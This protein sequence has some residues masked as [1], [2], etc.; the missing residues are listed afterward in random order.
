MNRDPSLAFGSDGPSGDPGDRRSSAA[1]LRQPAT[2]AVGSPVPAGE[3]P[4]RSWLAVAGAAVIGV[5]VPWPG[6]RAAATDA[7]EAV[8]HLT[9]P[10]VSAPDL[11]P[12]DD[13]LTGFKGFGWQSFA[14]THP[15]GVAVALGGFGDNAPM[16]PD[17]A[18]CRLRITNSIDVRARYRIGV[19]APCGGEIGEF[20]MRFAGLYQVQEIPLAPALAR[21]VLT[22][23]VE[24][25]ML[26]GPAPT[27]FFA[28]SPDAV[29][30]QD[31]VQLPHVL[32]ARKG[33]E[34][35]QFERR[36]RGLVMLQGF[37][38]QSG[39]VSEGLM[40]LAE[41]RGDGSLFEALDRYQDMYFTDQGVFFESP[42]SRPMRNQVGGVEEPLP[43]ATLARRKPDHPALGLCADFLP[44][45]TDST[46][47]LAEDRQLSTEANYTAAYP[48]AV[49]SRVLGRADLAELALR[50][51]DH[52][53]QSNV[54]GDRIL[55][56]GNRSGEG[57]L[58]NWCRGV[59]WYYL[60]IVRTL[61]A[62]DS[63]QASAAWKPEIERVTAF[64]I[65]HQRA[66]G[67]WGNF[68][69]EPGSVTDTSGSAGLAA[70]IARA[71]LAG[72][73]GEDAL[74]AARRT[75]QGLV[76]KL[77]PDGLLAGAAQ[78]HKGGDGLQRGDYRVLYQMGMGLMAQL[79]AALEAVEY[80]GRRLG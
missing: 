73:L 42:R 45:S 46:L 5:M 77:T 34:M 27:F 38:W 50:Q 31:R 78:S 35:E 61:L 66:D 58:P 63:P 28:P 55:Q 25:F 36:L 37:G 74:A 21:R 14:V 76:T 60:G 67:L 20:D 2:G 33:R 52:R 65:E 17:D 13:L 9:L 41:V 72:W 23:G 64:L 62:L 11:W 8:V 53:R 26:E 32:V 51:L 70:A 75:K 12:Q 49:L 71:C 24:L 47:A 40:D 57:R 69:H 19:R 6:R 3:W 22:E 56:L 80:G 18:E 79:M 29:P 16:V 30:S 4:R 44:R 10:L 43:W 59:C 15:G 68:I 48:A 7:S 54:H 1:D 39:C